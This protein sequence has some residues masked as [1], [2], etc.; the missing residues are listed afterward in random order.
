MYHQHGIVN[1]LKINQ[2]VKTKQMKENIN[3]HDMTKKMMSVIRGFNKQLIKEAE[4][5]LLYLSI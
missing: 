3:E 1:N 2:K 4:T 5:N